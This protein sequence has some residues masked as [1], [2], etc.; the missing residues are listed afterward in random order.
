[1]DVTE[2]AG[3]LIVEEKK[4]LLIYRKDEEWWEL[5]GGKVKKDESPTQAAVRQTREEISV[6][7]SLEKPFY[8]G[9]FQ[10]NDELF[11]WHGYLAELKGDETPQLS[12]EK[13]DRKKWFR[14][15]DLEEKDLAPNLRQVEPALRNILRE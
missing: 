5:P 7:V 6:E 10:H 12:E 9:E 13:F 4:L 15:P 14:K 1:M 2:I 8:S 11:L 3:S